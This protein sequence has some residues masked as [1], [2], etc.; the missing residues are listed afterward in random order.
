MQGLLVVAEIAMTMIVFVGGGLL[1]HSVVNLSHVA[2]GYNPTH[3]LTA[4]L[5]LPQGRYPGAQLIAF[6]DHMTDGLA[7]DPGAS[8]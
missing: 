8:T 2:L 4:Q 5:S 3:L 1:I 6:A 7:D